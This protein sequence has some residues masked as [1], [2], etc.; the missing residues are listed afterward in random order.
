MSL[1]RFFRGLQKKPAI[2]VHPDPNLSDSSS[3]SSSS[4]PKDALGFPIPVYTVI[5]STTTPAAT[6]GNDN[7]SSNPGPMDIVAPEYRLSAAS[8]GSSAGSSAT[9]DAESSFNTPIISVVPVGS[10]L[11][12]N[13]NNNKNN[14]NWAR[15]RSSRSSSASS[16]NSSSIHHL[17]AG[18]TTTT[19]TTAPKDNVQLL[20]KSFPSMSSLFLSH[21]VPPPPST[22]LPSIPIL[23][24]TA[25]VSTPMVNLTSPSQTRPPQ[26]IYPSG[27]SSSSSSGT[28]TTTAATT[29]IATTE[30]ATAMPTKTTMGFDIVV[31]YIEDQSDSGSGSRSGSSSCTSSKRNSRSMTIASD[32]GGFGGVDQT[33][34]FTG[35]G[36]SEAG[37]GG[38]GGGAIEGGKT[39]RIRSNAIA[40]QQPHQQQ[41][42]PLPQ[43]QPLLDGD[44][45]HAKRS[46][47][48]SSSSS[49]SSSFSN[50]TGSDGGLTAAAG[51]MAAAVIQRGPRWSNN[52][53]LELSPETL[54]RD[55]VG[56][57]DVVQGHAARQ[58]KHN[59]NSSNKSTTIPSTRSRSSSTPL[60]A[61]ASFSATAGAPAAGASV[62][63]SSPS[64]SSS[65]SASAT[66]SAPNST[67]ASRPV[68]ILKHT[69]PLPS[70]AQQRPK[71]ILR[72]RSGS[73]PLFPVPSRPVSMSLSESSSPQQSPTKSTFPPTARLSITSDTSSLSRSSSFLQQD[74]ME[75]QPSPIIGAANTA[76]SATAVKNGSRRGSTQS[77]HRRLS[78]KDLEG[79]RSGTVLAI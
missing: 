48:T 37:A 33:Q 43:Q 32:I 26:I 47:A 53:D 2:P 36:G 71:S 38:E 41:L 1:P 57:P 49:S 5:T 31:S 9:A 20:S 34:Q 28:N 15:S 35:A 65:S 19:T 51:A 63:S 58:P 29:E 13:G 14:N 76:T 16:V 46:S 30:I 50:N 11:V 77:S 79:T 45:Y 21:R 8:E 74:P 27:T 60:A 62:S 4:G 7:N 64:I 54:P 10:H 68:S 59:S 55:L 40:Q 17:P 3:S 72:T 22:T 18:F 56:A 6:A 44:E 23:T 66:G 25:T 73:H 42:Q 70:Q 24:S 78:A 61:P 69:H 67:A 39:G 12:T 52:S 75:Q